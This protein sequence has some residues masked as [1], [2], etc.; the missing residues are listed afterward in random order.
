MEGTITARLGGRADR[1]D[2]TRSG[3]R[4][5]PF[6]R[7]CCLGGTVFRAI[8]RADR[9]SQVKSSRGLQLVLQVTLIG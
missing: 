3:I 9:Q 5:L 6:C 7:R 2:G 4:S 1:F 8:A